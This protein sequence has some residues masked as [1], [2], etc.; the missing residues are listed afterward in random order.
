M[1]TTPTTPKTPSRR[2]PSATTSTPTTAIRGGSRPGGRGGENFQFRTAA[3]ARTRARARPS[4]SGHV[5]TEAIVLA[6]IAALLLLAC[7]AWAFARSPRI[8]AALA[9]VRCA[10]R[11]PRRAFA[12]RPRGPNSPTGRASAGSLQ[13]VRRPSKI[14]A[15]RCRF[16]VR[17]HEGRCSAPARQGARPMDTTTHPTQA[18]PATPG[19][20]LSIE[21]CFT[22]P[23]TH[24]FD[25]VAVGVA[26]RA[27]RP[28]RPRRVRADRRRVPHDLVAERHEHR[29]PEVLPRDRSATPRAS[30]R[31][32]R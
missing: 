10:T 13:K 19:V 5:S 26:R 29:H 21:R 20:A 27:H 14:R 1:P 12:R 2:P 16:S 18:E 8:R 7:A 17:S 24:P 3:N 15:A 6:A 30:T 28:R 4:R 31:S 32:S 25:T 9:A 11:W 23:G 22:S